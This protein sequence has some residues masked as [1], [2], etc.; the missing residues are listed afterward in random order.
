MKRFLG[1]VKKE[2]YHILRDTRTMLILFVLPITLVIIFGYALNNDLKN[3]PIAI[4]DQ[5]KD[6]ASIQLTNKLLS[7]GYFVLENNLTTEKD[8]KK[9]FEEGKVRMVIVFPSNFSNNLA[10]QK[11]TTI[12]LISDATDINTATSISG[13]A[14]NI[15][16][17]FNYLNYSPSGE[18]TKLSIR[19]RMIFNQ[20]LSS[21]YLYI[22]GTI[23]LVMMIISAMLTSVTLAREKETGT[24]ELLSIS[25]IRPLMMVV[26]KVIPYLFLSVIN[27][28]IIVLMGIFIFGLPFKGS[29]LLFVIECVL[30]I[31]TSLSLGILIST[32]VDTQQE[33]MYSSLISLMMPTML[34][35]GFIFPIESMPVVLQYISKIIPATH[36]ITIIKSIL[37]KGS[38]L[39][40]I[41]KETGVLII[42]TLVLLGISIRK[43]QKQYQ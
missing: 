29:I 34:L 4:L 31:V 3:V 14:L 11:L 39:S 38:G 8:I 32:M 20:R 36:F 41:W 13:Y 25:P 42:M 5:S 19:P 37:I 7:S 23:A 16:A 22:P 1:F 17:D 15:I 35:S 30:F 28:F 21:V 9:V 6:A 2:F 40:I 18:V 27:C 12:Q 24:M 43:I 26:G 33:A 10:H